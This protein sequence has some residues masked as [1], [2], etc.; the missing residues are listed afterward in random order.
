MIR[1]VGEALAWA[2]EVLAGAAH[3][4]PL[5]AALL[6]AHVTGVARALLVAYP[7]RELTPG[8]AVHF[9]ELVE[10]RAAGTPVA[11]LT[12]HRAFYDRDFIVSPD[13]L[14]PR[15]ESEHL[16]GCVRAW[17]GDRAGL[18]VVDVG[19]GSGAL[20][21]TLAAHL[22]AAR[23]WAVDV[24]AAALA[25]ARQ[26]AARH[27]V[28]ITVVQGDVLE[29][30]LQAAQPV[31]LIVANLPYIPR[32]DL[33]DLD[34]AC[35]EPALALDGGPDGLDVIRWLL[36]QAPQVLTAGGFLALEV[37]AGQGAA[38]R[39]LAAAAFPGAT[40]CVEQDYAGHDRIVC[41][42]RGHE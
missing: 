39:A 1:D 24:S 14:I 29:P 30:L 6:L 41:I 12:G 27:N 9:R 31:D 7:E 10:Q 34:V 28:A 3:S 38:V 15:P 42:E 37:G 19:T 20:A 13:V 21:I 4:E 33:A 40:I 26:N 32:A 11:Y 22:R 18:R 36:A 35:H 25:I 2:R 23:V 8:Q 17:A 5:D 16:I